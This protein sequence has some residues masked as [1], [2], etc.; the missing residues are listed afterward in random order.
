MRV[1]GRPAPLFFVSPTQINLQT[2]FGASGPQ[3]SVVV[4]NNGETSNAVSLLVSASSPGIFSL[5]QAGYG[6]GII[7]DA[8]FQ[9]ISEQNPATAGQTVIVFLTGL[10]ATDPSFPDGAP[11]PATPPFAVT[12]TPIVQFGGESG[13]VLFSG[14][15]P[16]FVGLYQINV[17]IPETTFLGAAVPVT[18]ITGNAINDTVDIAI[19]F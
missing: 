1:D 19:S 7:T 18:I 14:A 4:T 2:P 12:P 16:G 3:A 10:G 9:L 13:D 8:N 5:N 15:A 17:T 6:A 11:G